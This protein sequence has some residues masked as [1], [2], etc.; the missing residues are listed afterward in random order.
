MWYRHLL[1]I[2]L[3]KYSDQ[4]DD[5]L[6]EF[7]EIDPGNNI[8]YYIQANPHNTNLIVV[9][10]C[11]K[12]IVCFFNVVFS[13][14]EEIEYLLSK[15]KLESVSKLMKRGVVNCDFTRTDNVST[16]NIPVTIPMVCVYDKFSS[17]VHKYKDMVEYIES[18][19]GEPISNNW[20]V[21]SE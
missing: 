8:D 14:I 1:V 13:K 9:D 19:D 7:L 16:I 5:L 12:D 11:K 20:R 15:N 4:M 18:T 6:N 2:K 21:I 3:E 10:Q 17:W